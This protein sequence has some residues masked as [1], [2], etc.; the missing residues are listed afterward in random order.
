QSRVELPREENRRRLQNLIRPPQLLAL[1]TQPRQ[2]LNIRTRRARPRPRVD[3]GLPHPL[4]QR[5]ARHVHLRRHRADRLPLRGVL[6]DL[7]THQR[8]RT[9]T[10][11]A[12][13]P[14]LPRHDLHPHSH[15]EPPSNPGWFKDRSS[16]LDMLT[17]L[18]RLII[19]ARFLP[20]TPRPATTEEILQV[21]QAW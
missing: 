15:E 19:T 18:R 3:L 5:L 7:L 16:T 9:L 2:L 10:H 17:K 20:T 4:A 8:H 11:L 21:Q 12:R 1:P 13:V 6:P 14:D